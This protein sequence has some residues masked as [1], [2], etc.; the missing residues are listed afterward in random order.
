LISIVVNYIDIRRV[1]SK[2]VLMKGK[3]A[4]AISMIYKANFLTLL[5]TS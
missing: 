3:V 4:L 1:R 5:I 2:V